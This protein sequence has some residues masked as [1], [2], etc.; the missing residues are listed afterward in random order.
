M[1]AASRGR[2]Q[3]MVRSGSAPHVQTSPEWGKALSRNSSLAL[4]NVRSVTNKGLNFSRGGE[5][6]AGLRDARATGVAAGIQRDAVPVAMT[7]KQARKAAALGL[8]AKGAPRNVGRNVMTSNALAIV[9]DFSDMW[10]IAKGMNGASVRIRAGYGTIAKAINE[11]IRKFETGVKRDLVRW[12]GIKDRTRVGKGFRR[13]FASASTLRGHVRVRDKHILLSEKNFGAAWSR[14]NPGGTHAAWSRPQMARHTF[15]VPG[16]DFLFHRV[17]KSRR[18][19]D[20]LWGPNV[21]REIERHRGEVDARLSVV[22]LGVQQTA[23]RL[24]KM[25]V[26]TKG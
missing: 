24:M 16:K 18:P 2:Y 9:V 15:M 20:A 23:V 7:M 13:T 26:A 4:P 11:G 3:V 14:S 25:A 12:T 6:F 10:R 21:V 22:T 8:L 5:T 1:E 19:I 17:G